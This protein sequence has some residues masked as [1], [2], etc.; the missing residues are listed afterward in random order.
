M[1]ATVEVPDLPE[2]RAELTAVSAADR[3]RS[4]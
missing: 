2:A 3:R 4:G 1:G